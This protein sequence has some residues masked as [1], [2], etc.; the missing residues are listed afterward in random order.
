M[1]VPA[2][3]TNAQIAQLSSPGCSLSGAD[4]DC[5]ST[6]ARSIDATPLLSSVC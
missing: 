4:G 1:T 2:I 3:A 6:A 5:L